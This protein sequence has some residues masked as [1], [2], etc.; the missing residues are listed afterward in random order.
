MNYNNL[1]QQY[2]DQAENV[3]TRITELK[4]IIKNS[5]RHSTIKEL[6]TRIV[7]LEDIYTECRVTACHITKYYGDTER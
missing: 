2:F 1:A 3:Y 7:V 6:R 4:G 5:K